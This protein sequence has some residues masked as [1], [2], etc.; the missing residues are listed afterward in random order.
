MILSWRERCILNVTTLSELN[1]SLIR[2]SSNASIVTEKRNDSKIVS[3]SNR[4]P[5]YS[6]EE[7]SAAIT[8]G[9]LVEWLQQNTG[10]T[11]QKET[12]CSFDIMSEH[13]C[14]D[15]LCVWFKTDTIGTQKVCMKFN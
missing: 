1:P 15:L 5:C 7:G 10:S 3:S 13:S 11:E 12:T 14:E 4:I 9:K 2:Q 6:A 8:L